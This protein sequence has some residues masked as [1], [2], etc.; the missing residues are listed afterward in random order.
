M[1]DHHSGADYRMA[2]GELHFQPQLRKEPCQNIAAQCAEDMAVLQARIPAV[3]GGHD[4][5]RFNIIQD[6]ARKLSVSDRYGDSGFQSCHSIV[7]QQ[8]RVFATEGF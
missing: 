7:Q 3:S 4:C 2:E 8:L 5:S 1:A 6:V